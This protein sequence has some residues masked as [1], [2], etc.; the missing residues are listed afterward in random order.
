MKT[1]NLNFD[2]RTYFEN[3]HETY[4]IHN[5]NDQFLNGLKTQL[6]TTNWFFCWNFWKLWTHI[7]ESQSWS[8]T[9]NNKN[10]SE[11]MSPS[12]HGLSKRCFLG[13]MAKTLYH[14]TYVPP[15]WPS[16]D[17]LHFILLLLL[18]TKGL[19]AFYPRESAPLSVCGR[20]IMCQVVESSLIHSTL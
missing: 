11:W 14:A 5:E 10:G 8:S 13:F 2:C 17:V 6:L 7:F 18:V 16:M 1:F 15:F 12:M 19:G 9:T 4:R 20:S 3:P